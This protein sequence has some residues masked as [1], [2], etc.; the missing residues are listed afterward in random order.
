MN[1]AKKLLGNFR[2]YNKIKVPLILQLSATECGV[3]ALAMLFAYFDAPVSLENLREKCGA[4]R[5][6]CKAST[7][8]QVARDYG[9]E[10]DAYKMEIKEVLTLDLPVI[11]FW[12][13]N[14]Y[15]VIKGAGTNKVFIN[16]PALG[17]L[18][19]SIDEFDKS[20][21]GIVIV[22][23]PASSINKAK[24]SYPMMSFLRLWL[25]GFQPLEWM[26]VLLSLALVISGPL[27][28]SALSS[29]FVNYCVIGNNVTWLP[30]IASLFSAFTLVYIT[31]SLLQGNHQFKLCTKASIL[32]SMEIIAHT[33]QLPL[34]FYSLRQKSAIIAILVQIEIVINSLFKNIITSL[35]NILM[36]LISLV[37]MIRIDA[38]LAKKSL[39][40]I[41]I[42]G[43]ILY[44][45]S[46]VNL[47]YEKA[48]T[49]AIGKWYAFSMTSISNI[50][51]IKACALETTIL[52]QWHQLFRNKVMTQ[53]KINNISLQINLIS[54]LTHSLSLLTIMYWGCVRA[55]SGLLSIGHLMSFYTLHLFF[56]QSIDAFVKT[57]QEGHSAYA[58]H[59]RIDDIAKYKKDLRFD[60]QP[61]TAL[62]SHS[63]NILSIDKV[64]FYYNKHAA[65]VLNK[66]SLQ[67]KAGQQ[68]AL[69]GS[70]GSGK[71]SLAKLLCGLYQPQQGMI[72]L[73]GVDITAM[74]AEMLASHFAYVAQAGTLFSGTLYDNLTLWKK[75][76][77]LNKIYQSIQAAGLEDLIAERSL[78]GKVLENGSNFSGGEIQR[79]DIARALLQDTPIL[80]LDEATSALDLKTEKN[81]IDYLRESN[82]TIIYIAHRLATITHCDIVF[83]LENGA[84]VEQ[85][86]HQELLA[87]RGLYHQLIKNECIKQDDE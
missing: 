5:D 24:H 69:V 81:I 65:L 77:P 54:Q 1:I 29:I 55:G 38:D 39:F 58:S 51:T 57:I 40:I 56:S 26:F 34:I 30:W 6:G 50:E 28:N 46:R 87:S 61:K 75:D 13:F 71:S 64:S 63:Q 42:S 85:G 17:I 21:T 52:S 41:L 47:T 15:V 79:I 27:L 23:L 72:F 12:N 14:H 8:I 66:V 60:L 67:I 19:V 22:L 80:I 20:F 53:D 70:T 43:L 9:F 44:L 59:L 62:L 4:S 84:V 76:I 18:T 35:L 86:T 68:I 83:V 49:N 2:P 45:V 16:D 74:N 10:A 82:K 37:I 3:A 31:A 73:S 32:K 7:L 36:A 11:A 33:L 48:H 78:Y 25:S